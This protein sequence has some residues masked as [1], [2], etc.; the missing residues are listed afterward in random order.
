[1]LALVSVYRTCENERP[2]RGARTFVSFG[3]ARTLMTCS[4]SHFTQ[5]PQGFFTDIHPPGGAR[6]GGQP[7]NIVAMGSGNGHVLAD[8]APIHPQRPLY[9]PDPPPRLPMIENLPYVA[10]RHLLPSHLPVGRQVGPASS[11]LRAGPWS[12]YFPYFGPPQGW[13]IYM[14]T[15]WVISV[16]NQPSK[17]VI[18]LKA[19]T[20]RHPHWRAVGRK[21][22]EASLGLPFSTQS[23]PWKYVPFF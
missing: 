7:S 20:V 8:G 11:L 22:G 16:K 13:V 21:G 5:M 12:R 3:L 15:R 10:Y 2:A 18:S 9:G 17:W 4:M 6:T 14:K 23:I 1:M 19:D